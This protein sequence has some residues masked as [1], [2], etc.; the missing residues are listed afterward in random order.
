MFPKL[1]LQVCRGGVR[2]LHQTKCLLLNRI[3]VEKSELC[4]DSN[5]QQV[6]SLQSTDER[7]QH[8][9]NILKL[10]IG[11]RVKMGVVDAG[12]TDSATIQDKTGSE[13]TINM[14]KVKDLRA[15]PKPPIDL[16][17]AFPRPARLTWLFPVISS[18]GVGRISL[19]RAAKTEKGYMGKYCNPQLASLC[20][21][22]NV[23]TSSMY[24]LFAL[25]YLLSFS[26]LHIHE[27]QVAQTSHARPLSSLCGL[28]D[29]TV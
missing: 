20:M 13:M 10:K 16:I 26:L 8:L 3:F 28:L 18:L 11:D 6:I 7:F 2:H 17:L 25:P 4:V 21:F 19:I 15:T 12:I 22:V 14:G 24:S 23:F 29:A 27:R 9:E 1:R 5:L